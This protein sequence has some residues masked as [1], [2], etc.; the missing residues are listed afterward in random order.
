M[1][2]DLSIQKGKYRHY[3]G[4]LYEVTGTARHCETLEDMVIYSKR[5]KYKPFQSRREFVLALKSVIDAIPNMNNIQK[6]W[7]KK[8]AAL[9]KNQTKNDL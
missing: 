6:D 2:K 4:H 1:K 7:F 9:Y 3:K 8:V 5:S